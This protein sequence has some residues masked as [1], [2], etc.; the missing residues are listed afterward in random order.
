MIISNNISGVDLK[1]KNI[2][3]RDLELSV[4]ESDYVSLFFKQM[5]L[6]L[7][8]IGTWKKFTDEIKNSLSLLYKALI[9]L[10]FICWQESEQKN[11]KQFCIKE[12]N[13]STLIRD[14][15][16]LIELMEK[17]QREPSSQNEPIII[18]CL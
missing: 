14:F 12:W 4:E 2:L 9:V 8:S 17:W 11:I 1:N 6:E 15:I 7:Y 3:F 18:H 13:Q 10:Q 16:R 5:L